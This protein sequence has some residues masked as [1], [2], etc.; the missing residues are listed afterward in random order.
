MEYKVMFLGINTRISAK[1]SEAHNLAA[2]WEHLTFLAK[3]NHPLLMWCRAEKPKFDAKRYELFSP[4]K[5][6][7]C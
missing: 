5:K 6:L 2:N 7:M 4:G 3:H 1:N